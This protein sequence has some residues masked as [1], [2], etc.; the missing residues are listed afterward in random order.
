MT[1]EIR[2]EYQRYPMMKGL[3]EEDGMGAEVADMA[4][5]EGLFEEGLLA[6][7]AVVPGRSGG[8]RSTGRP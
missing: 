2:E 8:G 3:R 6:V 7:E 5:G 1:K 4:A